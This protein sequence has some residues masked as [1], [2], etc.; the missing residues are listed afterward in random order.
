MCSK[1]SLERLVIQIALYE[2]GLH[3]TLKDKTRFHPQTNEEL[4]NAV[5]LWCKD[6]K[7]GTKK[8]GHISEWNTDKITDM[9]YLF[10]C[11]CVGGECTCGKLSFNEPLTKWTTKNVTDFSFMFDGCWKF[12]QPVGHFDTSNAEKMSYMFNKCT[13]F[14]Q[15][16]N[17]WDVSN[18]RLMCNTFSYCSAFTHSLEKWDAESCTGCG[19]M[20][21]GCGIVD[22]KKKH[23]KF[24]EDNWS[25]H[26]SDDDHYDEP[27]YYDDWNEYERYKMENRHNN[28]D[29]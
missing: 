24:N 27:D 18:V 9:S 17:D 6:L 28:P 1:Q 8:Y 13:E 22:D 16:V 4:K 3:E 29:W 21:V 14:N 5:N 2:I 7:E 11:Y 12:N 26:D 10:K 20:L 23:P 19:G 15:D 25:N